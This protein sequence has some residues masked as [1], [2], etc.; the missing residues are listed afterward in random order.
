MP[1]VRVIT[2]ED[3]FRTV[4]RI[5]ARGGLD[6][7]VG[8]AVAASIQGAVL[9]G[10]DAAPVPQRRRIRLSEIQRSRRT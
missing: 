8:S 7:L 4:A 10:T 9:F 3:R 6:C 2:P 5:L 1:P